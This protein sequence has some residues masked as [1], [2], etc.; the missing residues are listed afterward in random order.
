MNIILLLTLLFLP[1]SI[2]EQQ[3]VLK[4]SHISLEKSLLESQK[5]LIFLS[6]SSLLIGQIKPLILLTPSPTYKSSINNR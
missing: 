5:S 6:K 2:S 4:T 3:H 1:E